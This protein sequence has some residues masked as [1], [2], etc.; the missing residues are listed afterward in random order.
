MLTIETKPTAFDK[1]KEAHKN[2]KEALV[3]ASLIAATSA[4]AQVL[5]KASSIMTNF[6]TELKTLGVIIIT[7]AL[8]WAGYKIAFKSAQLTEVALPVAG[9][10]IIGSASLIAGLIAA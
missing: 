2:A 8:I 9:G 3:L 4:E 1:I 5:G 6:A 7:I 10:I